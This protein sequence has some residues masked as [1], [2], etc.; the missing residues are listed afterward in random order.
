VIALMASD[1]PSR[2]RAY[3]AVF[4]ALLDALVEACREVY[5]ERLVSLAVFGPVGRDTPRPDSDINLMIV[6]DSLP[7]THPARVE[8]FG[9]VEA[10]LETALRDAVGRGV[11]TCLSPI[12]RTPEELTGGGLPFVDTASEAR[13]LVDRQGFLERHV[14]NLRERLERTGAERVCDGGVP[15]WRLRPMPGGEGEQP[16]PDDL[17]R[18]YLAKA[19]VRLKALDLYLSEGDY[20][21]AVREAQEAVEIARRVSCGM[22]P[23]RLPRFTTWAGA[24]LEGTP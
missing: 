11:T 8:E 14:R 20:S 24:Y 5:G 19:R 12:L 10:R 22:S 16:A 15:H 6:A 17:A 1:R 3:R 7:D 23:S 21:D 9:R 2:R 18:S 4:D 13:V